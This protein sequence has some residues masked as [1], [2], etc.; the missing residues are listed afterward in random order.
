M[1]LPPAL[2]RVAFALARLPGVGEKTARRYAFHVLSE[3]ESYA[4]ELAD[5]VAGLHASVRHCSI[6]HNLAEG[7]RCRVCSDHSR[8]TTRICVTEGIQEVLALERSGEF[9]GRYHVLHGV[10]SPVKGI[11]PDQLRIASLVARVSSEPI[12]EVI[13]ATNADIEGEATALFLR[14]LLRNH[15]VQVS[16]IATGVPMGGELEYL[17]QVTLARAIRDRRP[18]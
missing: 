1:R 14:K 12:A 15:D 18:L 10:L 3:S 2:E 9:R 4:A 11:G 17:D 5:A 6:C 7:E 13:V 16:R 8:D